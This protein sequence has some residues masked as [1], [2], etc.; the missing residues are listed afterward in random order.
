MKSLEGYVLRCKQCS[1]IFVVCKSCYRGQRYC[2]AVCRKLGYAAT[3]K[4]A[5]QRY[6]ASL[7]A[8]LDH[9]DRSRRYRSNKESVTDQ[10]SYFSLPAVHESPKSH[11]EAWMLPKTG[12]CTV[13]GETLWTKGK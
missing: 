2:G 8:K 4:A 12:A 13:C 6:E 11:L 7:E 5:K 10:A 3:I 1:S 9:R